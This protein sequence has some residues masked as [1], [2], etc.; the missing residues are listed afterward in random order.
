MFIFHHPSSHWPALYPFQLPL[1]LVAFLSLLIISVLVPLAPPP[2]HRLGSIFCAFCFGAT[3]LVRRGRE[4]I[5]TVALSIPPAHPLLADPLEPQTIL[6]NAQYFVNSPRLVPQ[7][8]AAA[9]AGATRF[10]SLVARLFRTLKG[11]ALAAS[12]DGRLTSIVTGTN[13]AM[14][15]ETQAAVLLPASSAKAAKNA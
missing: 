9:P 3:L 11:K 1:F 4:T 13:G 12:S 5:A 6:A 7:P 15:S 14:G 2:W 8:L 10:V